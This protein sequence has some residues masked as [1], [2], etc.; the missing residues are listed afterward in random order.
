MLMKK[1]DNKSLPDSLSKKIKVL[2]AP[3]FWCTHTIL[4]EIGNSLN[5]VLYLIHVTNVAKHE[6]VSF[7]FQRIKHLSMFQ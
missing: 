7:G 3:Y 1:Q 2:L 5:S 4:S 6:A